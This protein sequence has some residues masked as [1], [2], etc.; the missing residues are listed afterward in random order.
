M[1]TRA[2][3]LQRKSEPHLEDALRLGQRGTAAL[4]EA[5]ARG[6]SCCCAARSAWK[7]LH[8]RA[9]RAARKHSGAKVLIEEKGF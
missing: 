4:K 8:G 7:H 6:S 3:H 5:Q 1:F 2:I 9:P